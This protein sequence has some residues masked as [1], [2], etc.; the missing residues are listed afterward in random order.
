MWTQELFQMLN[1]LPTSN[2]IDIIAGDLNYNFL[3]V[4]ENKSLDIFTDDIQMVN[5]PTHISGYLIDHVYIKRTLMKELSTAEH[6]YFS[7]HDGSRNVIKKNGVDF[8]KCYI[9][10]NMIRE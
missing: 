5:K 2:S 7:S 10:S 1:Y 3:K 9:K 8:K 4:S 6:I